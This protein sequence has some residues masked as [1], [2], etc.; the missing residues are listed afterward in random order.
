MPETN[1][2]Q[3]GVTALMRA[4]YYGLNDVIEVLLAAGAEVNAQNEVWYCQMNDFHGLII[5]RMDGQL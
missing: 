4:A 5:A 1:T 2:A 3:Y